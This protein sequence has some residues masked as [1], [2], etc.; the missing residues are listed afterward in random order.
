MP[1]GFIVISVSIF[2]QGGMCTL[3]VVAEDKVV[4]VA[5]EHLEPVVPSKGDRV[6]T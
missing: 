3:F 1:K 5:S 6:S 2:F 4:N